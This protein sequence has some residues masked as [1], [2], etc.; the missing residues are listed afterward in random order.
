MANWN[1]IVNEHGPVVI[2]VAARI[3]GDSDEGED[4]AQDVF[5]QAFQLWEQQ[6]IENWPAL[7][8]SIATRRA[9]DRLRRRHPVVPLSTDPPTNCASPPAELVAKELVQRLRVELARLPDRQAEIFMLR[10]FEEQ[11]NRDIAETLGISITNVST[12]LTKA[13][14][15]LSQRLTDIRCGDAR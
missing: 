7:L 8:R 2:R 9:I 13:R 1:E 12:A 5:C 14:N 11:S 10:Y 6:T 4:V 15:S 3:L